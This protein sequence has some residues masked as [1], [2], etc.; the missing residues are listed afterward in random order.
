MIEFF[1]GRVK[2]KLF[3]ALLSIITVSGCATKVELEA[4]R[5]PTMDTSGLQRIAVM[6]FEP[7]SGNATY[8]SAA[9]HATSVAMSK[10]QATNHFKL[11]S[12]STVNDA[13]KKGEG[14]E[15]YVDAL[16]TGQI[17]HIGEKTSAHEGQRKDS[18]GNVVKY[19]YYVREV[20]VK[21]NYSF[22]RVRTGDLV[23]PL[24]KEGKLTSRNENKG[25]LA[26]IDS[27]AN[28]IIDGQMRYL[29][30]DVAPHTV[31]ISRSME[32]EGNKDLKPQMD[33]ARAQVREGNYVAARRGYLALWES[34]KSI[35]A[36]VNASI[37]Y[38]AMGETQDAINFMEQVFAETGSP[39]ARDTLARLK[40]ELAEQAGVEQYGNTKSPVESVTNHA[41]SEVQKV[42]P[43]G[44]RLWIY[45]NATANQSL[46]N[47]VI[48]N[49][50]SVFLSKSI[51]VIERQMI[52]L[53]LKEQNFQL[54]GNV[55]DNDF[56]SI[57]NLAGANTVV[58]VGIT[59]TGAV[60]RL[61]VRVLDIKAGIVIM[62]SST[63]SEWNL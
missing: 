35:A 5:T 63:G 19:T 7:T 61:Q 38:E 40:N 39:L 53:V 36:A 2:F 12:A 60:R 52:D 15:N 18:N 31:R 58:I 56:V 25:D 11:V 45:N 17:T 1:N 14:I 30:R 57:G 20:E 4:Q 8:Q 6:P 28:S 41:I 51:T 34:N 13:R 47:D 37:L 32:K 46:V 43:A 55:S 42:L 26:S 9:R 29:N 21:F 59:G 16:F 62:Q 27:L 50:I 44:A 33:A 10:I 49:M 54:S 24:N 3:C 22:T 48:D 23:G